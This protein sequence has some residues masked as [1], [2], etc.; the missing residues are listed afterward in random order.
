[1]AFELDGRTALITGGASGIGAELARRLTARGV[2][3][4]LIDVD[5]EGLEAVAARLAGAQTAVADVRDAAALTDAVDDLAARLGGLDVAVANAGIAAGG[6]LRL[7]GPDTVELTI[8]VN[9]LGVFRTA[10]A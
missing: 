8:D 9:L 2:R 5:G 3:V 6:P 4:G 1:M 7:I 10:R